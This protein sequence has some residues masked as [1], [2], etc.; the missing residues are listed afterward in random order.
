[1]FLATFAA[2][3]ASV[4]TLARAGDDAEQTL[5]NVFYAGRGLWRV[6]DRPQ[7]YRT[8]SD[9]GADSATNAL[10]LR[11]NDTHNP[12]IRTV[13]TQLLRTAPHY[14]ATCRSA[15]CA[16][17]S[18]TAAWDA[19]ALLREGTV[20][21]NERQASVLARSALR[22]ALASRAFTGGACADIPYQ[23]PQPSNLHAK[24]LETGA[25]AIKAELLLYRATRE[26][27]YLNDAVRLYHVARAR[28]LD[29]RVPLYTVHVIDDGRSCRQVQ[30]RFFAS[31]N[32]GMIWNGLALWKAT[33]RHFYYDEAIATARAV[34]LHLSDARNVFSDVQGE[35]DVVEPLVE[36]MYA[37]AP[38]QAFARQWIERNAGAALTARAPN[39]TF[40]RFFDGPHQN[41]TSI[42][43]SNGGLALEIA[44]AALDPRGTANVRAWHDGT[45]FART[46]TALPAAIAFRGSG[47]V[48]SGTI[49][50]L[51]QRAHVHVFIDGRETFDRTGLWQ[52]HSMPEGDSVFFAWRWPKV[53]HHVIHLVAG[54]GTRAGREVMR[55]S[56]RVHS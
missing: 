52:N 51:C 5:L 50:K 55:L 29:P 20:T 15:P 43:E 3:A 13:M 37:L 28:F 31:V 44:A 56:V 40:A 53:G 23:V 7:C 27:Q 35:N 33:G 19:V 47:I 8:N 26:R 16:A 6:C 1:M 38:R 30:H 49:G 21:G 25:N 54:D 4:P 22:F 39:G 41:Q 45:T 34:D 17:W 9:W 48:L 46:I 11:W 24:T 2:A 14:S 36:A 12:H 42:W 10:Y 18:D 32:G